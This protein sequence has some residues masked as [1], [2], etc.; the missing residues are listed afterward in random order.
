[1]LMSM[2]FNLRFVDVG[3]LRS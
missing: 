2:D 3:G 1:M